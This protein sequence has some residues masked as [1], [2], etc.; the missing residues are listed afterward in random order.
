MDTILVQEG[1]QKIAKHASKHE[2]SQDTSGLDMWNTAH[3]SELHAHMLD[4]LFEE[5]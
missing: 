3:N 5:T 2:F 1:R 4:V